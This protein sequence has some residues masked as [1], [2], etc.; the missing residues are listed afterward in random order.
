[1]DVPFDNRPAG[2]SSAPADGGSNITLSGNDSRPA[3]GL[4]SVRP[5]G[6]GFGQS[7]SKVCLSAQ[8]TFCTQVLPFFSNSTLSAVIFMTLSPKR[9]P[10]IGHRRPPL[11]PLG[12]KSGKSPARDSLKPQGSRPPRG[13]RGPRTVCR[14][15]SQPTRESKPFS[16]A[17]TQRDTEKMEPQTNADKR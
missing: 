6:D 11:K 10:D 14:V 7:V 4:S 5:A 1:M 3:D 2:E 15:G 9:Y 8:S 13:N 16:T 17:G 12:P